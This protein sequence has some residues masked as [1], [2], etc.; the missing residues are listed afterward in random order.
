MPE[1]TEVHDIIDT[2]AQLGMHIRDVCK[3]AAT[4]AFRHKV[5]VRFDFNDVTIE[6]AAPDPAEY[7]C[8][9]GVT[10]LAEQLCK[11]FDEKMEAKAKAYWTPERLAEQAEHERKAA[12]ESARRRALCESARVAFPFKPLSF[13]GPNPVE[14]ETWKANNTDPYGARVFTY[15]EDWASL[16]DQRIAAGGILKTV[17]Q[18]SAD[19]ADYDGISGAMFGMATQILIRYWHRGAELEVWRRQ[20]RSS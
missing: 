19:D 11:Q 4:Y 5:G 3:R 12:E 2:A 16:M 8:G 14:Y 10:F 20:T 17:A 7:N 9:Y 15:A 1:T 18:P 13:T 6:M